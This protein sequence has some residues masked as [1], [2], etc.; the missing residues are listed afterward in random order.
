M[1]SALADRTGGSE[2]MKLPLIH[3]LYE[4]PAWLPPL[5]AGLS[6]EGLPY[7]LHAIDGGMIDISS[8]PAE[9]IYWNR[10]SPS[11]HTRGHTTSVDLTIEL[12]A[13]LEGRGRRV[14]NGSRAFALEISKL[15]QDLALR[16]HGI[17]TPRTVLAVGSEE[18]I[19]AAKTF[20]TPFLTKH[21]CGGKGLGIQLFDSAVALEQYVRSPAFD[22][23][24][25]AQTILQ[26]YI[27]PREPHITRVE[28]VGGKF[29][30][31]ML[32]ST[33]G[34]FELCPADSCEL[35][36]HGPDVCPADGQGEFSPAPLTA[37][38][39]LVRQYLKLCGAEA[40][41]VA[42][43]EFVEDAQGRRYT[44]DINC[45]TNYNSAVGRAIGIDG[46]REVA[47]F[48]KKSL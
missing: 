38:D 34:G 22:P 5:E 29:L 23:G 42:G 15:Q 18:V 26:E 36:R 27:V 6:A 19:A 4:N 3:I 35:E 46:M 16:K 8:V 24:P 14:I 11:S 2:P 31:A 7:Q 17:L 37:D 12:L 48:I 47:R 40:I 20:T 33:A 44:Y 9:G 45:T 13:W 41:D 39:P 32:S 1:S 10:I 43:I 28:I 25:H 30:F 21:N